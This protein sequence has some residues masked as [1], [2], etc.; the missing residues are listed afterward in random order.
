MSFAI[1]LAVIVAAGV[2]IVRRYQTQAV[3]LCAGLAL[4]AVAAATRGAAAVLPADLARTGWIGFDLVEIVSRIMASRVGEI[5][6]IIMTAGGFARYMERIGAAD[7]MVRLA[8]RPLERLDRPYLVLALAYVI[9]Q[10]G[11]V[12]VPSAAGLAMLL[13]VSMYPILVR[14]GITPAAAAA[15]IG[16]TS[17]LDLGPASG[18]ANFAATTLGIGVAR[19]F[20]DY[21]I[22][23][24][25]VTIA[26]VALLHA[27]VQ[28]A[29]D[30]RDARVGR[31]SGELRLAQP[32]NG[33]PAAPTAYAVLPALPLLL[34][35]VFSGIVVRGVTIGVVSAMIISLLVCMACE[36]VRMRSARAAF[37]GITAF[38]DGMGEMLATVV[39]LIFAAETF[40]TGLKAMGFIDSLVG[41]A[42]TLGLADVVMMIVMLAII[43]VTTFLTGSGVS[44]FFSFAGIAPDVARGLGLPAAAFV[45]P[46]Q[47]SSGMF[48]SCSPVAGVIIAVSG[49]AGVST[50]EIVKR[51]AVPMLLGLLVLVAASWLLTAA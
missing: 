28:R 22:I 35:L 11:H 9:G 13:L 39:T 43:G 51:T 29:F 6:L 40:A 41:G 5:G 20:L 36:L 12:F 48:R 15:V 21:Q 42:G 8:V 18:T 23:P 34:L 25:A 50:F 24:A 19:Y 4:L 46:M 31:F 33:A 37:A 10:V 26:A 44:A 27:L 7:V 2:L 32:R 17:G 45:L 38:F 3:L 47:L 14:I 49:A 30:R 1:S 16:T